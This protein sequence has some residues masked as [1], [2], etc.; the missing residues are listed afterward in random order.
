MKHIIFLFLSFT[1]VLSFA[2]SFSKVQAQTSEVLEQLS[3]IRDYQS[4]LAGTQ[5]NTFPTINNSI[6]PAPKAPAAAAK[7]TACDDNLAKNIKNYGPPRFKIINPCVTVVGT[8][9][10]VHMAADGD[11]TFALNL[12]KPFKSMVTEV[13]IKS[14]KMKGGIWIEEICQRP[15][16]S[17]DPIH[18]G[19]CSFP[20]FIRHFTPPQIGERLQITGVF[21][22][23][24]REGGHTEIHPVSNATKVA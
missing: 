14:S 24:I 1:A 8:V 3:N 10:F 7:V 19:D 9:T 17:T 12:D 22:Q 20:Q 13:N 5:K 21:L 23:D 11:N 2:I 4:V 15:N 18:K 16:T 6:P